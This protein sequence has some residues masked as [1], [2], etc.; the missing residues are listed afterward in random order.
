MFV[1]RF[2]H[3]PHGIKSY[4]R[5]W[6]KFKNQQEKLSEANQLGNQIDDFEEGGSGYTFDSKTKKANK[7]A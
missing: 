2:I 5:L 7:I 4:F 6:N 1:V 3:Q